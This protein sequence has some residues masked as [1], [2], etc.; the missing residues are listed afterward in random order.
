MT[1]RVHIA[2]T[3]GAHIADDNGIGRIVHAQYRL[4]PAYGIELVSPDRA[5]VIAC[6]I[7]RGGLPRIDVLH[8]HGLYFD[9]LPH[10]PYSPWHH[11]ANLRIAASAR[12][13]R[14]ITVPSRMGCLGIQARYARDAAYHPP[15]H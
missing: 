10:A 6:H 14:A 13:A 11:T 2:P 15:R 7:E 8:C 9:D 4:L 5:D 3:P 12:A 1:L